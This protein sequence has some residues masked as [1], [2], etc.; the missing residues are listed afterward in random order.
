MRSQ[1]SLLVSGSA[2]LNKSPRDIALTIPQLWSFMQLPDYSLIPKHSISN[3]TS[4]DC[5]KWHLKRVLLGFFVGKLCGDKTE[6][7]GVRRIG[8]SYLLRLKGR[9]FIVV[10][11]TA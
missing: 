9:R 6:A 10:G 3:N 7:L 4:F 11:A 2:K 1:C 5:Y 8:D